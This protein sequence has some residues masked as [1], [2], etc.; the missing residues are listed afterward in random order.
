MVAPII[1]A[2]HNPRV[3]FAL[4]M[5]LAVAGLLLLAWFPWVGAGC[6]AAAYWLSKRTL[7]EES[8]VTAVVLMASVGVF[9]EI[10]QFVIEH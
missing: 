1:S 4:T 6:C 10:V 2:E 7:D 8:F 9:A 5:F 3:L